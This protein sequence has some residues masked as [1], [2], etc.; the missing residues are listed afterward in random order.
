MVFQSYSLYSDMSIRKNV[1]FGLEIGKVPRTEQE[2][3]VSRVA[4]MVQ[5]EHL[6]DRKPSRLSGGQRQLVTIGRALARD[7]AVP[8]QREGPSAQRNHVSILEDRVRIER[9][10]IWCR[11]LETLKEFYES[12]FGTR[13]SKKYVN[14]IKGFESFF[15]GFVEKPIAYEYHHDQ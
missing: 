3:T 4:K 9:V 8:V 2:G 5:I 6:L 1:C 13:S 12:Y 11:D 15:L 7:P 10:A 14:E